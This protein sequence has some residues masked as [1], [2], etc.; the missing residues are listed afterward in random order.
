MARGPLYGMRRSKVRM[1]RSTPAVAMI[2]EE[3]SAPPA[4]LFQSCVKISAGCGGG[5]E[6]VCCCCWGFEEAEARRRFRLGGVWWTGISATRWY[7][8]EVGVRRSKRRRRES[9]ETAERR[10]GFRGEK[11]VE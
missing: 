1:I 8:A 7:L 5:R 11:V 9:E 10:A 4:Y 6:M 3:A 2:P